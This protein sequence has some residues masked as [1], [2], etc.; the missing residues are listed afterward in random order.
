MVSANPLVYL[1]HDVDC[2]FRTQAS[3]IWTGEASFVQ[4]IFYQAELR[5][6]DLQLSRGLLPIWQY[7][8]LQIL[9]YQCCPVTFNT[10]LLYVVGI[11]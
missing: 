3:Q 5:C 9:S 8:I 10:Y 6:L 1:P 4:D 2:L 7:V 11:Y